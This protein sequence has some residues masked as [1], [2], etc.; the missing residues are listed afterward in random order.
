MFL[1]HFSSLNAKR[2]NNPFEA[3]TMIIER[4]DILIKNTYAINLLF[5]H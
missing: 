3:Q 1:F 5:L 4:T 2:K